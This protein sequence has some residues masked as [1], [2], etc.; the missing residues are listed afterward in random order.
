MCILSVHLFE[1][2]SL[3]LNVREYRVF[4]F[5]EGKKYCFRGKSQV[6]IGLL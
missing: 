6:A 5:L 2:I 3:L 4:K 1:L